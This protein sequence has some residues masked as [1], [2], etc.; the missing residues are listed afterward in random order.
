MRAA[1]AGDSK[2]FSAAAIIISWH[3][4][5][6]YNIWQRVRRKSGRGVWRRF[7]SNGG[8]GISINGG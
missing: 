4:A 8:H 5:G 2:S 3:M 1:T 6:I 7:I